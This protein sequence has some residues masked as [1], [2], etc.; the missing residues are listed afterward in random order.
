MRVANCIRCKQVFNMTDKPVCP[1]CIKNEERQ[2]QVVKEFLEENRGS[3]LE[4]IVE[5]TKVPVKR[6]QQFIKAGRLEGIEGGGLKCAR[7]GTLILKGK[8]CNK[9][10]EKI[11]EVLNAPMS[12]NKKNGVDISDKDNLNLMKAK[13]IGKY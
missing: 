12:S 8:Y 9:C 4:E 6:V 2:F 10:T 5:A 13:Q 1:E 11:V 7:C 3:T